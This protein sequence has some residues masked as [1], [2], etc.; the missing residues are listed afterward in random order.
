[1][2]QVFVVLPLLFLLFVT[3]DVATTHWLILNDPHG[4]LNEVNPIGIE[5]FVVYGMSGLILAKGVAFGVFG[6]TLMYL[7]FRLRHVKWFL[8][9]SQTVVLGL[10]ALSLV[11]V[12]NNF[13][14]MLGI[15]Y[16]KGVWPLVLI[17][18]GSS[19][20]IMFTAS[21]ALGSVFTN[22]VTYIW[23]MRRLSTH[24]RMFLGLFLFLAP[25]LLFGP[26]FQEYIW[27]FAVYLISASA[28]LGLAFYLTEALVTRQSVRV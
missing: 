1:M 25:V 5:L 10:A 12:F 16:V 24:F 6:A 14:A 17:G 15:L 8:E 28:A 22:G 11:T 21:L 3:L 18:Q 7:T 9:L 26:G 27:L 19:Y 23:G 20:A 13:L 2:T 4:I